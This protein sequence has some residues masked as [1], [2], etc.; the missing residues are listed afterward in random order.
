MAKGMYGSIGGVTKKI[1]KQYCVIGGVTKKIKKVY[2]VVGGVTR[3]VWNGGGITPLYTGLV[4]AFYTPGDPS[5]GS[6]YNPASGCWKMYTRNGTSITQ[7]TSYINYSSYTA[8]QGS[9]KTSHEQAQFNFSANGQ[10]GFY[11]YSWYDDYNHNNTII[12]YTYNK[13]T[14][15]YDYTKIAD[16]KSGSSTYT[17][18]YLFQAA[19]VIT[20]STSNRAQ[21]ADSYVFV[22]QNGDKCLFVD[23]TIGGKI[24]GIL[25]NISG[26]T[27]SYDKTIFNLPLSILSDVHASDDLETIAVSSLYQYSGYTKGVYIYKRDDSYNYTQIFK[28]EVTKDTHYARKVFVS[29]DGQYVMLPDLSYGVGNSVS[30][31]YYVNGNSVTKTSFM[32]NSGYNTSYFIKNQGSQTR[33]GKFL[34][35]AK[36]SNPQNSTYSGSLF[37]FKTDGATITRL[38]SGSYE[39]NTVGFSDF[40]E[41]DDYCIY[42]GQVCA[43]SRA[44]NGDITV[45]NTISTLTPSGYKPLCGRFIDTSF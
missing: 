31:L 16:S 10:T 14:G 29:R 32:T 28:S 5:Y 7:N 30:Q 27:I 41:N 2:A 24:V 22:N 8:N 36:H 12:L 42:A 39:I 13:N 45:G 26:K 37:K 6:S 17:V 40:S 25:C 21:C 23:I 34:S 18:D 33:D 4:H 11:C 9:G 3:L 15:S 35:I 44:S 38:D 1:K 43:C 20:V 19:G